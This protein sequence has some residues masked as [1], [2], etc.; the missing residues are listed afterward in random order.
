MLVTGL[1]TFD[2]STQLHTLANISQVHLIICLVANYAIDWVGPNAKRSGVLGKPQ[3]LWRLA[4]PHR[5]QLSCVGRVKRHSLW[6]LPCNQN[7]V[8][9][10]VLKWV[11]Y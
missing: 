4:L 1:K 8:V 3:L 9:D 2:S 10:G 6:R 11:R 7:A 5:R